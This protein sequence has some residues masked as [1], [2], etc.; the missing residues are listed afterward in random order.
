MTKEN[1]IYAYPSNL[2]EIIV[3]SEKGA[4]R[5]REF[6]ANGTEACF[7]D[8]YAAALRDVLAKIE[9]NQEILQ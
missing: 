7:W 8:G 5:E 6:S 4:R 3:A 2:G 1:I 9:N